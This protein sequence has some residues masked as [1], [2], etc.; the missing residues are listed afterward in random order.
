MPRITLK[1]NEEDGIGTLSFN[2]ENMN[3][4]VILHSINLGIRQ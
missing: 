1:L 4:E 3:A 2:G